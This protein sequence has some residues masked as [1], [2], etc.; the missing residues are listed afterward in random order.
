MEWYQPTLF[1]DDQVP[2][3]I[4]VRIGLV[5]HHAQWAIEVRH[6]ESRE[7]LG[8]VAK[9]HEQPSQWDRWLPRVSHELDAAIAQVLHPFPF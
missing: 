6:A 3:E 9:H 1:M 4:T 7:L 5:A 2:V 8:L